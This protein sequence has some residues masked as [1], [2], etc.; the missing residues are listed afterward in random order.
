MGTLIYK[1][2]GLSLYILYEKLKSKQRGLGFRVQYG[3]LLM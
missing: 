3:T 1:S 2:E